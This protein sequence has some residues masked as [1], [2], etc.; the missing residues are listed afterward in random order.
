MRKKTT[1]QYYQDRKQELP[2][3][4]KNYYYLTHKK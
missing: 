2:G 4:R 3:Y 1:Y